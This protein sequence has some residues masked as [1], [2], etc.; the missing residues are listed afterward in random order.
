MVGL[1]W[2]KP[3]RQAYPPRLKAAVAHVAALK[4][5]YWDLV[6]EWYQCWYQLVPDDA[7]GTGWYWL[8][9]AVT[10]RYLLVLAGTCWLAGTGWY[11]L[12]LSDT[13]WYWLV[14]AAALWYWLVLPGTFWY[15]MVFAGTFWYWLV[16]AGTWCYLVVLTGTWCYRLIYFSFK[17][18]KTSLHKIEENWENEKN[19]N[20][21]P[22][23]YTVMGKWEY[24]HTWSRT[25]YN[26][27]NLYD[28][29]IFFEFSLTCRSQYAWRR[30]KWTAPS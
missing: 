28:I 23:E 9:L 17:M 29:F 30:E 18:E 5:W 16:L 6:I 21:S 26:L 3:E 19:L 15:W 7:A 14:L 27:H 4:N 10:G 2:R 22:G 1:R 20:L 11:L 8:L 24:S 12:V 25:L 13:G